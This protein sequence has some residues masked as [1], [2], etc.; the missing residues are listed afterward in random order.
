VA[1]EPKIGHLK[2]DHRLNRNFYKGIK[3]DDI[4]VMLAASAMNFKRMMNIWKNNL[5]QHFYQ[6]ISE[7]FYLLSGNSYLSAF[8]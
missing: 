6:I 5:W 8:S 4:N 3:G 2:A 7:T 1:I